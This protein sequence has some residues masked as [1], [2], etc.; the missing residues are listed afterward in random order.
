M[1]RVPGNP[2][3]TRADMPDIP[4]LLT[5]VTSVFNPGA[6]KTGGITYLML[7]VQARSR[8]TFMVMAESADGFRFV[9]R[10]EIV[11]FKGIETVR[12]RIYHVYDA[13]ITPL[14]GAHY[15]M[16]AMDMDSGC[17]LG[18]ARTDDLREFRF[19]GVTSTDDVRNGV[20]F[21]EKIGG[22]YLRLERPNKARLEGGPAT[23]TEIWLAGSDDLVSW[24]R[25]GPVM[26]GRFHYWDE[27][28]GSGPPPV[29]TRRGW[30]H[31]YHGVA[32]H[33]G[34]AN[35]YQAGVV[36]LD[37]A[38]PAKVIGRSRG[39]ILEPRQPFE[40]SGQVPNVVFPS[41]LVVEEFDADGYALPSSPVK[42]Y[43]GAA[44][45]AVGLAE[46]T[47]GEL[48]EATAEPPI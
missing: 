48:L 20:L 21:P 37:L 7:R 35:I 27:Y 8:E 16:F 24:K 6:V 43:Y 29:K 13:R 44:D 42:I 4:P 3:L 23:G 17:Q 19:L 18:L 25:L 39:N 14:E 10:P 36:L 33:F 5:D 45:T 46:T 26:G 41:G 34:S 1:R 31:I 30:L 11:A 32:T 15:V 28:I 9:V 40:L 38:D 2:I 12:E 47:V 22:L